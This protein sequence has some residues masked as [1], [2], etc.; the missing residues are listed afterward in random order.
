[1][2]LAK[3]KAAATK[4][5]LEVVL[6]SVGNQVADAARPKAEVMLITEMRLP[7]QKEQHSAPWLRPR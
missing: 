5:K 6:E 3:R 2:E 4:A 7:P 1:M